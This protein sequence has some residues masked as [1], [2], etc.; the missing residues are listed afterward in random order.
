MDR[1]HAFAEGLRLGGYADWRLPTI[2]EL[3]RLYYPTRGNDR[4][5]R[6]PFSLTSPRVWSSTMEEG[7]YA[8]LSDL[9]LLDLLDAWYFDF[10]Q[11][12]RCFPDYLMGASGH[13]PHALCVRRSRA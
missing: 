4:K 1:G 3:E 8:R 5:I 12:I 13:Y 10:F 11:G 9:G 7:D 2:E 6:T